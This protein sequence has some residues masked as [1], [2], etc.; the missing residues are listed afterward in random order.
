M[1]RIGGLVMMAVC[2]G[3]LSNC[4]SPLG[5]SV[6][7][8]GSNAGDFRNSPDMKAGG[9]SVDSG[10]ADATATTARESQ[11]QGEQSR[12]GGGVLPP[13]GEFD[14]TVPGFQVFDPCVGIPERKLREAGL[15]TRLES[16]VRESGFS[17]CGFEIENAE[18]ETGFIGLGVTDMALQELETQYGGQRVYEG[19]QL[20][21]VAL[22]DPDFGRLF[23]TLY[24]ETTKGTLI[25]ESSGFGSTQKDERCVIGERILYTLAT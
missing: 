12:A 10:V 8:D 19:E 4:A 14:R 23:C 15:S 17:H 18:G 1:K 9:G 22:D 3:V 7:G 21:V 6:R 5:L 16:S 24:L 2:I 25:V 13:L 11:A 20:P